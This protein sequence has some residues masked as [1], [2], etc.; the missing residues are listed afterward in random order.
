MCLPCKKGLLT[1][2]HNFTNSIVVQQ[3]AISI[4]DYLT[5]MYMYMW[6]GL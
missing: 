6:G 4:S 2:K 5:K 3:N 1:T